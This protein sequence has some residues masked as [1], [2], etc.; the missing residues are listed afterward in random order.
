MDPADYDVRITVPHG[1]VVGAT[2]TLHDPAAVLSRRTLRPAG[3]S[4][5]G[6]RDVVHVITPD[7][8]GTPARVCAGLG[9]TADLALHGAPTCATSPGAPATSTPG[10][11]RR[12]LVRDSASGRIDTVAIN[13]YFRL[14]AAAAA[15][16]VGGARFTRDAIEQLS[17]YLWPYPWPAMTFDG[18]GAHQRRHGVPDD[19]ADAAVGRHPVA[20]RRP[21]A[22][23]RAHVVP[24]AG[25]LERDAASRGWTRG[26]PSST[27]RRG[28][29]RSTAS[30]APAAGPT[31]PS[32]ASAALYL[33]QRARP[34][35]MRR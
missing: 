8:R 32:R 35:T 22:R 15:W 6:H 4:A 20:G 26:S 34:A 16:R 13:S 2:G 19:D 29:A 21:D 10:T 27:S 9:A 14:T 17:A 30:R 28:C 23:D 31:T 11:R 1:W 12:A 7:E 24:D 33:R 5:R 25:R 18:R 3:R